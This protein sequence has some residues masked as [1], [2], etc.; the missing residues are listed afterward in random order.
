MLGAERWRPAGPRSTMTIQVND[1]ERDHGGGAKRYTLRKIAIGIL[2]A[3]GVAD[4]SLWTISYWRLPPWQRGNPIPPFVTQWALA[5]HRGQLDI[6]YLRAVGDD[7]G[8]RT[9]FRRMGVTV[10]R[11]ILSDHDNSRWGY[12]ERG[13]LRLPFCSVTHVGIPFCPVL[14]LLCVGSA[15]ALARAPLRRYR[16]GRRGL[17]LKCGY[18]LRGNVSG[19]CPEC[20]QQTATRVNS[21]PGLRSVHRHDQ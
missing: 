17:C 16:R 13:P 11:W 14:L 21:T 1:A 7:D 5:L 8:T 18:D 19:V 12:G 4:L 15:V 2:I 6:R 20:G 10:E 3:V 9:S